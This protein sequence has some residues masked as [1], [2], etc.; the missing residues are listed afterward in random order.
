LKGGPLEAPEVTLPISDFT[1]TGRMDGIYPER[2]IQYRYA[3]L[4]AR[5][6]LRAWIAHLVLNSFGVKGYP[7]STLLAGLEA[8][9]AGERRWVAWHFTP[10]TGSHRILDNLLGHYWDGLKQPLAFFPE[11]SWVYAKERIEK[12]RP[13]EQ[14]LQKAR[15]RWEGDPYSRGER[16]DLYY[17]QCFGQRDCLNGTFQLLSEEIFTPMLEHMEKNRG[18]QGE[19]VDN[20]EPTQAF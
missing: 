8:V 16:E 12:E 20:H 3:R 13:S 15:K 11:S 5:D 7:R 10:V 2:L 4:K 17:Q 18:A 6:L 14:A 9:G 19:R 1:L